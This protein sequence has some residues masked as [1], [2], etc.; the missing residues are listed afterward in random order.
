MTSSQLIRIIAM[1]EINDRLR[2]RGLMIGSIVTL[3]AIVGFIVVPTFFRSDEPPPI[4]LGVVG[5][6]PEGFAPAVKAAAAGRNAT[7]SLTQLGTREEADAAVADGTVHGALID[8]THLLVPH[9]ND[10]LAGITD[11]ALQQATVLERLGTAGISE[12]EA[13][14]IFA[15]RAPVEVITP[16]GTQAEQEAGFG[17]AFVATVLLFLTIQINA[18]TLLTGTI[19]EKSSRVVEVILGTVRPWQLLA[20]KLIGMSVLAIGQLALYVAALLGSNAA[21]SAFDLPDATGSAVVV[22]VLMF[23]VGFAFFAALYAVAGAM[24]SSS[25]D[26]QASAMP[27]G[28]LTA[29]IY[30]AVIIGVVPNP[31]GALARVLT[32][33]PPSAPFAIPARVSSGAIDT[34]E[35]ALGALL[36]LVGTFVTVRLAGRLYSAAVLAGGKLT[37]REVWRAEPIT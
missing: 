21:V 24:S 12:E 22:G 11:Q 2:N 19:E 7:V 6:V 10:L 36:T 3:L 15:A 25:E 32:F 17:I 34:W 16:R 14:A 37:W 28:F 33:L 18:G 4:D 13:A 35:I 9:P 1:R 30:M 26:A 5:E 8:G 20:G 27:L 29:G 31:E 23:V